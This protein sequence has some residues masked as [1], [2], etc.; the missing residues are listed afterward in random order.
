M[1][2][3]NTVLLHALYYNECLSLVT[4]KK[5]KESDGDMMRAI[6]AQLEFASI[7]REYDRNGILFRTHLYVPEVH[8][9]TGNL[10]YER[11]DPGHVL[12]VYIP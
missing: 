4:K 3:N 7:V 1:F 9:E 8:P 10:F 11:E 5:D 2:L 12:K 6:L